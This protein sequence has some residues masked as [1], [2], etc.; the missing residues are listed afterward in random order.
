M[1]S[2]EGRNADAASLRKVGSGVGLCA[3]TGRSDGKEAV[4]YTLG[5]P[6]RKRDHR[7]KRIHEEVS[8]GERRP[9]GPDPPGGPLPE[10]VG[11]YGFFQREDPGM[12]KDGKNRVR[13]DQ[14]SRVSKRTSRKTR[15]DARSRFR[16]EDEMV[17]LA[18]CVG[19]GVCGPFGVA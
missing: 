17:F 14:L 9:G 18:E 2:P 5:R 6:R 8:Y 16:S 3:E 10:Y 12:R 13:Y 4:L 15:E 19:Q 1:R 7:G 11:E